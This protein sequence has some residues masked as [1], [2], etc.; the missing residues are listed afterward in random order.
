LVLL[1][2]RVEEVLIAVSS[3]DYDEV[4]RRLA[5]AG[6]LHVDRPPRELGGVDRRFQAEYTRS[7]E[8]LGRIESYFYLLG[9]EPETVDRIEL[10][11]PGWLGGLK[12]LEDEY[13]QLE[14][15]MQW[16]E[17]EIARLEERLGDLR[18]SKDV[19]EPFKHINA[20]LVKASNASFIGF[21]VGL[22]T[23]QGLS[24]LREEAE[25]RGLLL[26]WEEV[27]EEAVA[28]AIAGLHADVRA[29]MASVRAA[30]WIPFRIPEGLPGIPSKAYEQL[31]REMNEIA[32]KIESLKETL[33]REWLESLKEYYT[34][35]LV[36]SSALEILANTASRGDFRFLRGF[37]DTRDSE[38]L[39]RIVEDT[40]GGAYVVYSLGVRKVKTE[41][42]RVPTRVELP[43]LVKPFHKLVEM[44]GEPEP[45]E[46]VPTIFAAFTMPIFFGLMFPDLGHALLVIL[47]GYY[48]FRRRDPE[49]AYIVSIL[50]LAGAVTGFLAGEFFGPLTGK[51]I[52]EFWRHLGFE[53]PPLSSPVD[54]AIEAPGAAVAFMY[55]WI[56]ISL[57]LAGY[58]LSLGTLLGFVNSLLEGD[59]AE[60]FSVKLPKFILFLTGSLPFLMHPLNAT[61]AT[62]LIHDAIFGPRHGLAA[63]LAYTGAIAFLWIIVGP[64]VKAVVEGESAMSGFGEGFMEFYE[65]FL[66][67]LGNTSSFL[68]ILGLSLAHASLMVGF[69]EMTV[70]F[71][72]GL[73]YLAGGV[74]YLLG[75]LLTAGLEAIIVFAHSLRLHYYEWFSKF[76][77]GTGIPFR[78]VK[79]PSG[80]RIVITGA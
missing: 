32:G 59:K 66:M 8:R 64:M 3:R 19:I 6:I 65:S 80:V 70:P 37:V 33:R 21:A 43:R 57:F 17:A 36:L 53:H 26:A 9:V 44:Y 68:R 48:F 11:I 77:K 23:P 51:P 47:F 55:R 63:G 69:Y 72:H 61:A 78:A 46:V 62:G 13:K 71:L 56:S 2:R 52:V 41:E 25:K 67:I 42:E 74:I 75:N 15:A 79:L 39:R 29:A 35:V 40:T 31:E 14:N 58:T 60:A 4:V 16:G 20:D 30:G 24:I 54:V 10:K 49:W 38:R 1:P 73:A 45:N 7:R 12:A 34:K 76:Y 27:G 28:V 5:E 50:G 22:T 18:Q